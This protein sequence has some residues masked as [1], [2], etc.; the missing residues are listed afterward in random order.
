MDCTR[1]GADTAEVKSP[2]TKFFDRVKAIGY[3]PR[4][5]IDVG[6]ASG[7]AGLYSS[8]PKAKFVMVEPLEEFEPALVKISQ[9]YDAQY[10]VAAAGPEN[11][12]TVIRVFGDM[13]D[14]HLPCTTSSAVFTESSVTRWARSIWPLSK[15]RAYFGSRTRGRENES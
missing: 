4:F 7:T 6:V 13:K 8:F 14:R 11:G 10:V 5:V 15:R 9:T 12:E 1:S 3:Y 2:Y